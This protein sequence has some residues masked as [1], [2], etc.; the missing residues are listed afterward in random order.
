MKSNGDGDVV[1]FRNSGSTP[2]GD[3]VNTF[4]DNNK[5][6]IIDARVDYDG[7]NRF[8]K[9][10][11]MS[12][13]GLNG[14]LD[15]ATQTVADVTG[16][17]IPKPEAIYGIA[18]D[19]SVSKKMSKVILSNTASDPESCRLQAQWELNKRSAESIKYNATVFGFSKSNGEV[20]NCGDIINVDDEFANIKASMFLN[21]VV[22]RF[23]LSS[24]STTDLEFVSDTI[25]RLDAEGKAFE[26]KKGE[27]NNILAK[28][29]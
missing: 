23:D 3:L 18:E 19:S 4:I 29:L 25:Y 2:S 1:V 27:K 13:G 12:Q 17:N 15:M 6:N 20:W 22:Y 28:I 10:T 11:V 9:I 14:F 24:G 5:G 7:G 26:K 16:I 8:S 21:N